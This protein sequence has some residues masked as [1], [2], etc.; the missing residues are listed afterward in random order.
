M[1]NVFTMFGAKDKIHVGCVELLVMG[2]ENVYDGRE[3]RYDLG[4]G[5]VFE[6][7]DQ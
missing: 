2:I 6:I 4:N 7:S 1:K 5:E 3:Y